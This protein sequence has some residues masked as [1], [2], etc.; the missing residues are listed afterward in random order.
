[1]WSEV[2]D[3]VLVGHPTLSLA[4]PTGYTLSDL[5]EWRVA[6]YPVREADGFLFLAAALAA[7]NHILELSVATHGRDGR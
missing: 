6:P 5:A 2:V 4:A 3:V 7:V 1:M